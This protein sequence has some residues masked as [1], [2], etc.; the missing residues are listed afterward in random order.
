M[1]NGEWR[2]ENGEWMRVDGDA[3]DDERAESSS[4]SGVDPSGVLSVTG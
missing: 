1:K 4:T 3:Q 2:M